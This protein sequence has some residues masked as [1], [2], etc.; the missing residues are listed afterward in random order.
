MSQEGQSETQVM[1]QPDISSQDLPPTQE[2]ILSQKAEF[3]C[4]YCNHKPFQR[5]QALKSHIAYVHSKREQKLEQEPI[6]TIADASERLRQVLAAARIDVGMR[7]LIVQSFS[8]GEATPERLLKILK[9]AGVLSTKT[10]MIVEVFFG[11]PIDELIPASKEP[12]AAYKPQ[13]ELRALWEEKLYAKLLSAED[14]ESKERYER[15]RREAA[16][17]LEKL[18][19]ESETKLKELEAKLEAE[20]QASLERRLAELDKKMQEQNESF[21]GMVTQSINK[22]SE[23][24][25]RA[26]EKINANTEMQIKEIQHQREKESLQAQLNAGE[27]PLVSIGKEISRTVRELPTNIADAVKKVYVPTQVQGAKPLTHDEQL[28]LA[29][30]IK[31]AAFSEQPIEGQPATQ[32][33]QPIIVLP[34][35][36]P[37]PIFQ[38][39]QQQQPQYSEAQLKWLQNWSQS[40]L[41]KETYARYY[42]E[43]PKQ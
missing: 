5:E 36:P 39:Q 37:L 13:N 1:N 12:V 19:I 10:N 2:V 43:Y 3:L 7:E 40:G 8:N 6:D 25:Q 42:G 16:E 33:Q 15:E 9:K 26:I 11:Q 24:F 17:R 22:L 18:R 31:N 35:L 29:E 41:D 34:Q 27:R 23:T 21:A 14:N 20:R 4:P 30:E 32:S 28:K 38:Q